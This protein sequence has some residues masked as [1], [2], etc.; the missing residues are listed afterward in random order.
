M[1]TAKKQFAGVYSMCAISG[2]TNTN[3]NGT[4]DYGCWYLGVNLNDL[5]VI[6]T[7]KIFMFFIT[8]LYFI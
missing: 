8:E 6:K 5:L 2:E 3:V 7:I 4:A 1:S